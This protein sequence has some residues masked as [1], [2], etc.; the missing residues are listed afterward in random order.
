ATIDVKDMFFMV[1]IQESDQD[2]FAFTWQGIQYT[3]TRLPQGYRHSPTLAHHALA[4]VLAEITPEEGVKTYQYIDDI[5]VGGSNITAVGQTQTKIITHL[6]G[7]GLQIPTE[8]VQLPSSEV[9]FLGIWWRGGA[10][11]IPPETLA[12]L[13]Q[14]K[15][16]GNKKGL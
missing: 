6:E 10:A 2:K 5:L 8:K 1:P 4:Q 15:I 12:T 16:P 14:I 3:F 13:E 7:L 11:C 9:R